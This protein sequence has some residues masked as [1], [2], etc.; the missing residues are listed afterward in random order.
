MFA[1]E[2]GET[3][4]ELDLQ[5]CTRCVMP[6]THETI[7]YDGKGVCSVCRQHEVKRE[8]VDWQEK[9]REFSQIIDSYRGKGTY[10]CLIPSSGGKDSTYVLYTMLK[11]YKIKP[12][13][14]SFDHG[15]YRPRHLQMR[16]RITRQLGVDFLTFRSDP[17]IVKKLMLESLRRKGDFCWHCHTGVYAWPMQI[18]VKFKIPLVIWGETLAEYTS[19]SD[20]ENLEEQ[21]EKIF[22][23][24]INLGIAAEDMIGMLNDG[25]ITKRDLLPYTYPKLKELKAINYKSICYGAYHP[26]DV[27][28]QVDIIRKELDWQ[29]DEVEGIP[30][31]Y[32]YTKIECMVNG[33]RDYLKYIK[34]GFGRTSQL[35]TD[36]IR[37]GVMTRDEAMKLVKEYDGRK[38]TSLRYFLDFVGITEE[39]FNEIAVRHMISPWQCDPAT[40]KE[41]KELY[42]QKTW[43][44]SGIHD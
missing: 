12:L 35:T 9:E 10:D 17:K 21:D 42:D 15:F 32:G 4:N 24:Y 6:E 25:T 7:M 34:R 27:R 23:M 43:E 14:V 22:N 13:V 16:D 5:R 41:G 29:P 2:G 31:Q 37:A 33:V 40:L 30:E 20:F 1:F 18:A 11:K 38:P 26:W 19:Y 44:T 39:E 28:K 8:K 3:M 36:D